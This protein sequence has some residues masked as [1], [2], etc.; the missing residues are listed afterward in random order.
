MFYSP[1][2][3]KLGIYSTVISAIILISA[4]LFSL[5]RFKSF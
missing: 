5:K 4:L 1:E 3:F 2:S